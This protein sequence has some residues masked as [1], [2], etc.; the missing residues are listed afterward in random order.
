LLIEPPDRFFSDVAIGVIH[1]RKASRPAR[2]AIDRQHD[3][4]WCS[5]AREV[6]P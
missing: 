2:F 6:F 3:L 4:S 1:E 5:H